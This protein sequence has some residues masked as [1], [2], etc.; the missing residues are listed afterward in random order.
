MDTKNIVICDDDA[1][2]TYILQHILGKRKEFKVSLAAN[3]E[4]GWLLI[5]DSRPV[6]LILDLDMPVKD[7]LSVLRD[8]KGMPPPRPY[9][10]V[11]SANESRDIQDEAKSLGADE[12]M[13]KPFKPSDLLAKVDDLIAKGKI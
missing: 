3:G 1:T 10:I 13:S 8:L 9:T 5:R 12:V 7:G 11:L 4:D 2:L 6:L